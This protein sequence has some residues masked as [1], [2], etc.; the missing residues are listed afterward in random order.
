VQAATLAFGGLSIVN[1]VTTWF[2]TMVAAVSRAWA[3]FR[4]LAASLG[5]LEA[6]AIV[7]TGGI[8][9]LGV[10]LGALLLPLTIIAGVIGIAVGAFYLFRKATED[11]TKGNDE[12]IKKN[13]EY[14][15]SLNGIGNA[16]KVLTTQTIQETGKQL[17][18]TR[19]AADAQLEKIKEL[20][21]AIT[22]SWAITQSLKEFTGI[23]A[24]TKELDKAVERYKK[25]KEQI[26]S[27]KTQLDELNKS[28][29][30]PTVKLPGASNM[31]DKAKE[32]ADDALRTIM[33]VEGRIK[34]MQGGP[35]ALFEFDRIT[36]NVNKLERMDD[37]LKRAG[38]DSKKAAELTIQYSKALDQLVPAAAAYDLLRQKLEMVD[39]VAQNTWNNI[40]DGIMGVINGTETLGQAFSNVIS[41]MLAD[42]T[43]FYLRSMFLRP[44]GQGSF[45]GDIFGSILNVGSSSAPMGGTVPK[46]AKGGGVSAGKTFM[47]GEQG[48]ELF[49]PSTSG[50]IIPNMMGSGGATTVNINV[51][52]KAGNTK[53]QV[54]ETSFGNTRNIDVIIDEI[55][56]S[57]IGNTSSR[58]NK[59]LRNAG[60]SGG[61]VTR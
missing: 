58:T 32:A 33:Q 51:V 21:T 15:D 12:I 2:T 57:K 29:N 41:Q 22:D 47:V 52:N 16:Q 49:S 35:K 25:Y 3:A 10:A 55:V 45:L 60:Q 26:T 40:E 1:T 48:P 18:A 46:R 43:K 56:A 8:A 9:A 38:V 36:E 19:L 50:T 27:F 54:T 13:Q 17:L 31:T 30:A 24:D 61:V 34:A 20:T 4:L 53:A 6:V 14:I 23:G 7:A 59:A 28:L 42:I 5:I 39:Q 11:V 44:S 37:A